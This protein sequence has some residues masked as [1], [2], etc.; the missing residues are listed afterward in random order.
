M[1]KEIIQRVLQLYSIQPK[2]L[3]SNTT[4]R[5]QCMS[6]RL[7]IFSMFLQKAKL[8]WEL[9]ESTLPHEQAEDSLEEPCMVS[10]PYS[11]P[12]S[13]SFHSHSTLDEYLGTK[14]LTQW[15]SPW[16]KLFS[17][18]KEEQHQGWSWT[19]GSS[20]GKPAQ[21]CKQYQNETRYLDTVL[22]ILIWFFV[23]CI[24]I[25]LGRAGYGCLHT[26]LLNLNTHKCLKE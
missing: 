12:F 21:C 6:I 4:S 11:S 25:W 26:K 1:T 18:Q 16:I 2:L 5:K 22:S 23:L 13:L 19:T 24:K 10:T 9:W 8:P 14:Y 3:E 17:V 7:K 15:C 20:R